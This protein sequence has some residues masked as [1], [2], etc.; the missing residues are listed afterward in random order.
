M[1]PSV[2][3]LVVSGLYLIFK[4]VLFFTHQ[5]HTLLPNGHWLI[6]MVLVMIGIYYAINQYV[7]GSKAYNWLDAY[8]KGLAVAL[9]AAVVTGGLLWLYYRYLDT[10]YLE[11]KK[12]EA[13]NKMKGQKSDEELMKANQQAFSPGIFSVATM[14]LVN[15]IGLIGSLIVAMLGRMTLT[16]K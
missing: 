4:L 15:A 13:F 8:K 1:K 7:K 16:K 10:D 14:F 3:G 2:V 9:V 5:Q 12:I 11:I 6:L